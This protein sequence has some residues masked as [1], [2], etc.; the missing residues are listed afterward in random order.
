MIYNEYLNL[1][2]EVRKPK[3]PLPNAFRITNIVIKL[4]SFKLSIVFQDKVK[5]IPFLC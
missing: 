1:I 3:I 2:V 5:I 4:Q